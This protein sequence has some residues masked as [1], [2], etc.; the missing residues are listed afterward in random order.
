M[1]MHLYMSQEALL[2][3]RQPGPSDLYNYRGECGPGDDPQAFARLMAV[4]GYDVA[5]AATG[6]A[7]PI[8]SPTGKLSTEHW[9]GIPR[10]NIGGSE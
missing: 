3:H 2:L 8:T 4:K 7:G 9:R 10:R 5:I 6:E 1:A